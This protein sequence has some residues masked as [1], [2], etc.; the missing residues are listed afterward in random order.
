M[1]IEIR[2]VVTRVAEQGH[3][4]QTIRIQL[5]GHEGR[6]FWK[7]AWIPLD[8]DREAYAPGRYEFSER[9]FFVNR[10]E[11]VGFYPRLQFVADLEDDSGPGE[12]LFPSSGSVPSVGASS[13]PAAASAAPS[14]T[15]MAEIPF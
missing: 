11:G 13:G 8:R 4:Y 3:R 5:S 15:W 2:Q 14:N 1:K 9:S 10:F 6:R 12:G 7:D